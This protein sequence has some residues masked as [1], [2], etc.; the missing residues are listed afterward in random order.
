[1]LDDTLSSAIRAARRVSLQDA[2]AQHTDLEVP[3]IPLPTEA[4]PL[5]G[6][7]APADEEAEKARG[8]LPALFVAVFAF[9]LASF[10][11]RNSD[12]WMHLAAGRELFGKAPATQQTASP[13]RQR[14]SPSAEPNPRPHA[15]WLFDATAY[16]VY[17]AAGGTGLAFAKSLL[18]AALALVLFLLGRAAAGRWL[19]AFC[20]AL[21]VLAMATR[22]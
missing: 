15:N 22:L 16:V 4:E 17:S 8:F 20:T 3:P 13:P 6:R 21:A 19:S 2:M 18:C 11:A 7:R 1:M 5:T 9:L 14:V 12:I 10:P